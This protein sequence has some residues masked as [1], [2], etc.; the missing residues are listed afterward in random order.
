MKRRNDLDAS[1]TKRDLED[2]VAQMGSAVAKTI[3]ESEERLSNKIEATE[4]N[5]NDRI[6]RTEK[7]L[8]GKIDDIRADISDHTRRIR[9]LEA[10]TITRREFNT[11]K[12]KVQP[13]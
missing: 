7:R 5:V 9:D 10:D 6:D 11:F 8:S 12:T 3:E 4:K 1:V 13:Q 2:A